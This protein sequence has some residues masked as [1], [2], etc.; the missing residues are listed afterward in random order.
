LRICEDINRA[1][2]NIKENIGL[3]ELMQH[4]LWFVEEC[5]GFIDQRK[6][7]KMQWVQGT[8]QS[9]VDNLNRVRREPSR[10]FRNKKKEYLK[11]KIEELET[12]STIKNMRNWYR[13]ISDFKK[14]CQFGTNIVKDEKGVVVAD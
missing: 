1:W 2:E 8:G 3:Y 4:K 14:G 10:H 13:G 6:Q 9:S 7:A 12:N 5:L 11:T